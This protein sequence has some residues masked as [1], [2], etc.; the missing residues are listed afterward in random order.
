[1][2][3]ARRP[4]AV[5]GN[6][7]GDHLVALPALR[8]LAAIFSSRLTLVCM[9]GAQRIFFAELPL[10]RA[11]ETQMSVTA[12]GRTFDADRVARRI[13]ATD[14]LLS[15]NP[16][17]SCAVDRLLELLEP[18]QSI[19]FH[20]GF[21]RA[22]PLDYGMH[23]A[24]LAFQV[25]WQLAPELRIEDFGGPPVMPDS[26]RQQARRLRSMVPPGVRMLAVHADTGAWKNGE[27]KML[28][29]QTLIRLLDA[30]L[31]RHRDFVV[32]V[33]GLSDLQLD[34]GKLGDRV[35]PCYGLD[36]A[37]SIALVGEADLFLG[38]DSCMLHAADLYRVPGVGLFGPTNEREFGFR[39]GPHR[40][41][42]GD[43]SMTS[44]TV[45]PVLD[46]LESLLVAAT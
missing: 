12:E 41:V 14:L 11:F 46:A 5:F 44:I 22:L 26:A 8:A 9:P 21:S 43:G 35:I 38:I 32:F 25:P 19:G 4:V 39:F 45:K 28:H 6:G 40:H 18:A 30:F 37:T 24:D 3:D 36:L 7:I 20:C 1:M 31:D 29:R 16:W 15:L 17:H 10:R 13:G 27:P 34:R 42:C 23:S 2:L 33:V